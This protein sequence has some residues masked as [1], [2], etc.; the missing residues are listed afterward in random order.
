MTTEV[1]EVLSPE[2]EFAAAFAEL[3]GA[4]PATD[5]EAAK[6]E[7]A[8]PLETP[9]TATSLAPEVKITAAA[10]E[11]K[12]DVVDAPPS[13][14]E[15]LQARIAALKAPELTA[16]Q[17]AAWTKFKTE[18]PEQAEMLEM[19]MAHREGVLTTQYVQ[20]LAAVVNQVEQM[21]KPVNDGYGEISYE[22]HMTALRAKEGDY[23]GTD[24]DQLIGEV[25]AWIK[26]QPKFLQESY[27]RVYNEGNVAEMRELFTTFKKAT[28]KGVKPEA[29]TTETA[30]TSQPKPTAKK[31]PDPRDVA[32]LAPVTTSKRSVPQPKGDD[33]NDFNGAWNEALAALKR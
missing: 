8:T 11:V 3:T 24:Y 4:K 1:T 33:P 29:P 23:D 7:T 15:Q 9:E 25:P 18:W 22:R 2:D 21:L 19:Q 26:T 28:G 5:D 12:E 31:G 16:D 17:Q 20:A 6:V 14:T 13:E 27:E 32:A 10:P 30:P